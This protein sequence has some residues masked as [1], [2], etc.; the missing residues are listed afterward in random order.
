MDSFKLFSPVLIYPQ[1][2]MSLIAIHPKALSGRKVL[3]YKRIK[4]FYIKTR[5][6]YYYY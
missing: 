2:I 5:V 1:I 4:G 3:S 6:S